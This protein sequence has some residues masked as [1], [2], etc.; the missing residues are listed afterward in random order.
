MTVFVENGQATEKSF[1]FSR[2]DNSNATFA[3]QAFGR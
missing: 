3:A 1:W 2:L